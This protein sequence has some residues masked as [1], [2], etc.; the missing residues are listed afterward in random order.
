MK[1]AFLIARWEYLEKIK[2][3]SFLFSMFILPLII[4]GFSFL[5]TILEQKE[6]LSTKAIGIIQEN[7]DLYDALE[8]SLS[9]FKTNDNQPAFLLKRIDANDIETAIGKGETL[10]NEKVLDGILV[11]RRIDPDSFKIE[12]R[13]N[14][15]TAVRL[16]N[17]LENASNQCITNWRLKNSNINPQI[18]KLIEANYSLETIKISKKGQT[19]IKSEQAYLI[20]FGFVFL[21]YFSIIMS[22]SLLVRSI[23]E[24][25]SNRIIEILVSSSETTELMLGKVIGLSALGITQLIF[26]GLLII[27]F[28]GPFILQNF[29][30]FSI[31]PSLIYFLLGY[32]FYAS[33]FVGLGSIANTEQESQS[34]MSILYL[35]IILPVIFSFQ[36]MENPDSTLANILTYIPLTTPTVI[37]IKLNVIGISLIEEILTLLLMFISILISS[38]L[39]GKIFRIAILSY[40]RTPS[41][42]EIIKW[43]KSK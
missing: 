38:Y 22:S 8:N 10:V 7:I 1:K 35:I 39:S 15:I 20:I 28:A 37:V 33:L 5:P 2:N 17:R 24:E 14:N 43:L 13:A 23:A 42:S 3:K 6:D 31:V 36:I 41:I 12:Y 11:I 18:L 32:I 40:G 34:I 30:N 16:I 29:Q 4:I 25:K 26:W 21:L 27:S 19:K 9:K